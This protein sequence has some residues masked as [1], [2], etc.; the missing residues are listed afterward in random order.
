MNPELLKMEIVAVGNII[1]RGLRGREFESTSF[2]LQQG[3]Y[4]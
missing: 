4:R 1:K 3:K 2:S